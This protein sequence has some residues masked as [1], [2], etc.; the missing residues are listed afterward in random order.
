MKFQTTKFNCKVCLIIGLFLVMMILAQVSPAMA[1]GGG[2]G[3]HDGNPGPNA[4]FFQHVLNFSILVGLLFF[5]LRKP[6]I[7]FFQS[8]SELLN[9]E[10]NA[11]RILFDQIKAENDQL[12]QKIASLEAE[13]AELIGSF[14]KSG[15]LEKKKIIEEAQAYADQIKGDAKKIA[16]TEIARAYS[17]LK[18]MVVDLSIE[19]AQNLIQQKVDDSKQAE[20]VGAYKKDLSNLTV[21]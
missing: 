21:N 7:A 10:I 13:T 19:R 6:V 3:H 2:G 17:E 5:F 20:L 1:A 16:D 11:N 8:R 14:Q 12:K 18:D 9:Q 15:E 4:G